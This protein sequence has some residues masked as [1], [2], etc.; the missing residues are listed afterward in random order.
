MG[1]RGFK[2]GQQGR[3]QN[4]ELQMFS[5]R[6]VFTYYWALLH[7]FNCRRSSDGPG[8]AQPGWLLHWAVGLTYE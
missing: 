1:R 3:G 7:V 6:V 2:H 8:C 5:R 4:L